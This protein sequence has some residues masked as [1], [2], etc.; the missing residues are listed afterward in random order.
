[1]LNAAMVFMILA[2]ILGLPAVA[3]S[4][5]VSAVGTDQAVGK[6]VSTMY[7]WLLNLSLLASFGSI[8]AGLMVRRLGRTKACIASFGFAAIFALLLLQ[9]NFFGLFSSAMLVVAGVMILVAPEEQFRR[10]TRIEVAR[11]E[12]AGE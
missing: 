5:F 9:M 2:G 1:M 6:E 7:G 3:C 8:A 11:A 4:G 10:V 12:A